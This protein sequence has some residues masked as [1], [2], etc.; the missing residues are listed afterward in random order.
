V[1]LGT[2]WA[3]ARGSPMG[4][5]LATLVNRARLPAIKADEA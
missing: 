5:A 3:S 2:V 1:T 4:A